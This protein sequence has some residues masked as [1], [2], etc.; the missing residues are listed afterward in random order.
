MSETLHTKRLILSPL[1]AID[2]EYAAQLYTHPAVVSGFGSKP[3]NE[4]QLV[5]K[6]RQLFIEWAVGDYSQFGIRTQKSKD[7]I[8]LGGIRPTLEPGVG[9]IGYVFF[10]EWWGNG[11]ASEAVEAWAEWGFRSVGLEVIIAEGVENPASIRVLEKVG[12]VI[13]ASTVS[14]HV[15][16]YDLKVTQEI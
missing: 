13:T 16:L 5:K 15:A 2:W 12:F 4:D 9:E 7:F 1:A 6:K 3:Y 10:P 14:N 8:G 11:F